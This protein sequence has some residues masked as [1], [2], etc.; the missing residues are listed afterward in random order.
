MVTLLVTL[1]YHKCVK[2]YRLLCFYV[3]ERSELHRINMESCKPAL[4]SL[5]AGS[6]IG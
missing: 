5:S 2:A 1:S 4:L 6:H 3:D